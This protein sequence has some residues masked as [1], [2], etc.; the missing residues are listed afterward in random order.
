VT[1]DELTNETY[2]GD[3]L[4]ARFDGYHIVLRAPRPGEEDHW[5]ALEPDVFARLIEYHRELI[6]ALAK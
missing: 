4:Y 3:G 6:N 5:V 1:L 2:L